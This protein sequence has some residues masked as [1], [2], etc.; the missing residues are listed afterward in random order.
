MGSV[1]SAHH[2]DYLNHYHFP[3]RY[4]F[5]RLPHVYFA[6]KH[7]IEVRLPWDFWAVPKT[8]D[9]GMQDFLVIDKFW[10]LS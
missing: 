10:S 9:P 4:D 8:L 7:W 1:S 5:S 3:A 2:L 6:S